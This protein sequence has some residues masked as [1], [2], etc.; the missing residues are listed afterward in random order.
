[1]KKSNSFT[2]VELLVVIGIIVILAGLALPAVL[3]VQAKAKVTQAKADMASIMT[4][5]KGVEG[6]YN[7]VWSNTADLKL[8]G[9]STIN[10][11]YDTYDKFI[12]E[13]SNPSELAAADIQINKRKIKFLD[14]KPKFIPNTTT[15]AEITANQKN[16][17]WRDPWG[18]Q[19]IVYID[20]NYDDQITIGGR[21]LSGK[22]A[23]YSM[24]PN[25]TDQS[26]KNIQFDS[27][28]AKTDDDIS[29]WN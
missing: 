29:S 16:N 22:I 23:I 28:A 6:T 17:L 26:G 20:G 18:N 15:A 21:T 5:L 3:M 4:A 14:P 2:L 10:G 19:Y 11:T 13:L 25:G 8:G 27:D 7:R 9:G 12:I 1:M 24:G